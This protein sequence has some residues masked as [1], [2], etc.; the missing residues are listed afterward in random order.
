MKHY[1]DVNVDSSQRL[2]V[3][4][5]ATALG[6]NLSAL[7]IDSFPTTTLEFAGASIKLS[8]SRLNELFYRNFA[9]SVV[10]HIRNLEDD[11]VYKTFVDKL[12]P[13]AYLYHD[14][15]LLMNEAVITASQ[16]TLL[17]SWAKFVEFY[18][19]PGSSLKQYSI[20]KSFPPSK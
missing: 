17:Q 13:L 10:S 6:V 1:L 14:A 15:V 3:E 12:K 19:L 5:Q 16:A 4:R 7:L 2:R 18:V 8:K 11:L 9:N 20:R